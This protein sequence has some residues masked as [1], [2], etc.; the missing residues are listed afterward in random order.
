M[1]NYAKND[2]GIYEYVGVEGQENSEYT[3]LLNE[4]GERTAFHAYHTEVTDG[5]ELETDID[6]TDIE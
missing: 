4:E 5:L 2:D 6:L 1:S 3:R